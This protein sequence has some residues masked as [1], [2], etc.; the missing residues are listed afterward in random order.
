MKTLVFLL[1]E[2]SARDLIEG[3]A[4]RL[5][6]A[7]IHIKYLVFEGKQD[8]ESQLSR[9]LRSWLAPDSVFVVLRDQ[10]AASCKDVKARLQALVEESVAQADVT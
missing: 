7:D 5:V 2:P 3:I 9:K 4:P 8:L 1:E 10:D 6:A